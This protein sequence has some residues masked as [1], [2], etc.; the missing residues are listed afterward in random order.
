MSRAHLPP[1]GEVEVTDPADAAEIVEDIAADA[2]NP[3]VRTERLLIVLDIDGTILLEDE[4]L[5][6]GVVEAVA[7][8]QQAGHEVM[9]ATGRSWEST[10][11]ILRVLEIS[12][13]YVV[14]SNGAVIMKRVKGDEVRYE[15][16]HT[17]TFDPAEVLTLLREHLP[18][19][20]YMVE[21]PD[22]RRLYT[23]ELDD[24][25]LQG[26]RRVSFEELSAQPASRVVVVSPDETEQDFVDLVARI[27][28]NEVSYAVGWTAWLDIAPRGVDKSSALALVC[29]WLGVEP[30]HVIVIGDGRNDIGMFRWAREN[31]G[32]AV[33]MAQGVDEVRSVAG[34]TTGS[35]QAGGVAEVLRAL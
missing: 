24:W 16:F 21:L 29:D 15:R 20:R 23:E 27:G 31:G 26:A 9:L 33:A 4:S 3:A 6:P 17:E 11:G 28:L 32:R 35:V 2:E 34:E 14:C 7:H 25:N 30:S 18:N 1:A 19:A 10:R 5:S 22:G 12:P 13:T 8:A